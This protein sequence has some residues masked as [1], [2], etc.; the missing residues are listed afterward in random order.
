MKVRSLVV[1]A[2]GMG[3][4]LAAPAVAY[5]YT[6]YTTGDVNQRT[7]PGTGYHRIG[8][9]GAGSS[10][11]VNYCQPGWCSVYSYL[12]PGWVSSSYLSGG[13]VYRPPVYPRIYPRVYPQPYPYYPYPYYRNRYPRSGF[14]LY[15]RVP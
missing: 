9:L 6:S 10:L 15:F 5:A 14:S 7:G 3:M 13:P 2:L 8:T 12:G 1:T 4:A 11:N